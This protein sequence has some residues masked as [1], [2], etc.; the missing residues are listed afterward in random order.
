MARIEP[1]SS[2]DPA[3]ASSL[4][5]SL[6]KG[7]CHRTN[8]C[9]RRAHSPRTGTV[10]IAVVADKIDGSVQVAD[11]SF[12]SDEIRDTKGLYP[13][14]SRRSARQFGC[15]RCHHRRVYVHA[16]SVFSAGV[17]RV[18]SRA[19]IHTCMSNGQ[20]RISTPSGSRSMGAIVAGNR[21]VGCAGAD[22]DK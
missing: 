18:L 19:P 8:S 7:T 17:P 13:F 3:E 11:A 9:P 14:T 1:I 4:S 21:A 16:V 10:V 20:V 22:D 6:L 2:S 5:V 15:S 12:N